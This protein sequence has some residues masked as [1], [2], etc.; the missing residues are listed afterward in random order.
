VH[1]GPH[2]RASTLPFAGG[3][4][5]GD[6]LGW[7]N[8]P[9]LDASG[10]VIRRYEPAAGWFTVTAVCWI[11]SSVIAVYRGVCTSCCAAVGGVIE[12]P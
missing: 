9:A 8:Y 12:T 5:F 4:V 2:D 6:L 7:H 11:P 10:G 1:R 3:L